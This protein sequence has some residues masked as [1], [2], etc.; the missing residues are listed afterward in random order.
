MVILESPNHLVSLNP[1]HWIFQSVFHPQ[2]RSSFGY[3]QESSL[4]ANEA[5]E[6]LEAA[7][8][9]RVASFRQTALSLS[10]AVHLPSPTGKKSVGCNSP[11]TPSGIPRSLGRQSRIFNSC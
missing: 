9:G 8:Q 10:S 6:S 1:G 11:L 7:Q 4:E 3:W 5:V 2:V